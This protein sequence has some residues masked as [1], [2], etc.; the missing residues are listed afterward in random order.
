M[1]FQ[2]DPIVCADQESSQ[3]VDKINITRQ[4]INCSTKTPLLN[5][6]CT[7]QRGIDYLGNFSTKK[8]API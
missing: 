6:Q 8:T 7:G 1:T 2:N 5:L 4:L 3:M